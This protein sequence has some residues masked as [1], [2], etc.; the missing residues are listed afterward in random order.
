[1]SYTVTPEYIEH[2]DGRVEISYDRA[3]VVNDD[4]RADAQQQLNY[5]QESDD[6]FYFDVESQT[7]RSKYAD[8][9]PELFDEYGEEYLE[10]PEAYS[11]DDEVDGHVFSAEEIDYIY[12]Q[13]G[14]KETYE[15][16]LQFAANN[17]S[18]EFIEGYD[19]VIQ[20]GDMES[21]MEALS[22]LIDAYNN[23]V[24][25]S[26][27]YD[28]YDEEVDD[29]EQMLTQSVYDLV[30]GVDSYVS[31]LRWAAENLSEEYINAFDNTM[32][33]GDADLMYPMVQN[34]QSKF[35]EYHSG[36]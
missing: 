33:S 26:S 24:D 10:N 8:I 11:D 32:L 4:F 14:G 23:A 28:E 31:M 3:Q 5:E 29:D 17:L 1:M 19:A 36:Y 20:S 12:D 21:T 35:Y 22:L 9:D 15:T 2:P 16:L 34:L 27:E 13:V 6:M 7:W 18:Q 30:G 25:D